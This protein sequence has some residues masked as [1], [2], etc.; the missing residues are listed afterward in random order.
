MN[1]NS[2]RGLDAGNGPVEGTPSTTVPSSLPET[3]Y[4]DPAALEATGIAKMPGGPLPTPAVYLEG[5]GY[6]RRSN[7]YPVKN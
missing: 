5:K 4:L 2:Q 3:L 1:P 6:Q 7:V